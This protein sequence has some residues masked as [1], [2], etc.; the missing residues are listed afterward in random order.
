MSPTIAGQPG[1]SS[2]KEQCASPAARNWKRYCAQLEAT[3]Q[4]GRLWFAIVAITRRRKTP[5]S[6]TA[7]KNLK[8]R[9][10]P[11]SHHLAF[12][13]AAAVMLI[14]AAPA[15]AAPI[16]YTEEAIG[17]GSL[18]GQAF[19]NAEVLIP[20]S[21]NTA[22]ITHPGVLIR[23]AP[24][25][26]TVSIAGVGS[27][28]FTDPIKVEVEQPNSV[29]ILQVGFILGTIEANAFATYDLATSF[30]PLTHGDL[31]NPGEAFNTT[32]G[33]FILDSVG[34]ATFTAFAPEPA[35]LALFGMA[36][37]GLAAV[38]SGRSASGKQH[39]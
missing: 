29:A 14:T 7:A 25:I 36:V 23:N 21:G 16:R 24:I 27:A 17:S 9:P 8:E 22:N 1:R 10:M 5:A 32:G 19:T 34:P 30:G 3:R 33:A 11:L 20:A 18:G 2:R 28:T 35:T 12:A 6:A 31:Y 26:A 4:P 38:R 13:A 37:L 39:T 15:G